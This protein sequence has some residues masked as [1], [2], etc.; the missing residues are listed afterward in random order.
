MRYIKLGIVDMQ[1]GLPQSSE[2]RSTKYVLAK[3][4]YDIYSRSYA[5]DETSSRLRLAITT[6]GIELN[7]LINEWN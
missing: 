3:S 5:N 1:H 4:N 7:D 6:H 2:N